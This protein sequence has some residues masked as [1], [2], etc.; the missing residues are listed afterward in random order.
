MFTSSLITI[1]LMKKKR[2][3]REEVGEITPK[4]I[5][6]NMMIMIKSAKLMMI[7]MIMMMVVTN[8]PNWGRR[9]R[10][11]GRNYPLHRPHEGVHITACI[12]KEISTGSIK[13]FLKSL[14]FSLEVQDGSYTP[15][16]WIPDPSLGFIG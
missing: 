5:I 12:A 15:I 3:T 14:H 10:R 1:I 11:M 2:V 7:V 16:H 6:I 9:R 13:L 8:W 4:V